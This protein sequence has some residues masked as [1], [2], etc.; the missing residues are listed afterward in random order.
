MHSYIS[1]LLWKWCNM[2]LSFFWLS[3]LLQTIQIGYAISTFLQSMT[4]KPICTFLIFSII[5]QNYYPSA[6]S[7]SCPDRW[8]PNYISF[9][10]KF[11]VLPFLSFPSQICPVPV[12]LSN[13][14]FI[15]HG[16]F[17]EDSR[18]WLL[19]KFW[20]DLLFPLDY[21]ASPARSISP[22]HFCP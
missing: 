7:W 5:I 3:P 15:W 18:G 20:G 9:L 8:L 2:C 16:S 12:Q 13:T 19:Y 14:V 10:S 4:A 11:A 21:S 6:T 17:G 1:L 22:I